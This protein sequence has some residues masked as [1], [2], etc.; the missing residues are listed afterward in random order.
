M[1]FNQIGPLAEVINYA[2]FFVDRFRGIDFVEGGS[3]NLPIPIE[4]EGR[5]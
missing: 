4:I 2:N 1:D 3:W 5:R